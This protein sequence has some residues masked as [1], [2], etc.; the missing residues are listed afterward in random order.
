MSDHVEAAANWRELAAHSL[1]TA[2]EMI[3]P[4]AIAIML[5]IA[6]R[7]ERLAQYADERAARKKPDYSK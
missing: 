7:Y 2:A 3:D 5:D 4:Q 6:A 1:A